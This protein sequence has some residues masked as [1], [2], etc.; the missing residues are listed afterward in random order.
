MEQALE[1]AQPIIRVVPNS[2]RGRTVEFDYHETD[3]PVRAKT[4]GEMTEDEY[5]VVFVRGFLAAERTKSEMVSQDN[6]TTD[7]GEHTN[8]IT[9]FL[10]TVGSVA[11]CAVDI[12]EGV[13]RGIVDIATLGTA[14]RK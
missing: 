8:V 7:K 6:A 1:Q 11:H 3:I 2:E 13:V 10:G 14:R 5:L 9:G 12:A 4:I